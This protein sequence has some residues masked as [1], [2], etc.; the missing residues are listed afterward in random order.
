MAGCLP[1]LQAFY[2]AAKKRFDEDAEFKERAQRAVVRLQG[3]DAVY[4]QA[5]AKICDIS[6]TEFAAVYKRLGIQLEEKVR[7]L[8]V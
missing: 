5:W 8:G 2:K 6:R 3:G 7:G 1:V 4:R